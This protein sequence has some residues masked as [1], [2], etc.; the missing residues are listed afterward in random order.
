MRY[1]PKQREAA[2]FKLQLESHFL[3]QKKG[4]QYHLTRT[5]NHRPVTIILEETGGTGGFWIRPLSYTFSSSKSFFDYQEDEMRWT[6]NK[7]IIESVV[8]KLKMSPVW[9]MIENKEF[10]KVNDGNKRVNKRVVKDMLNE[11]LEG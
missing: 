4:N 11:V 2:M 8:K 7:V 9:K 5:I 3:V 10:L 6:R 1:T